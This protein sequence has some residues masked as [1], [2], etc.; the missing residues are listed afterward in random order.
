MYYLLRAEKVFV[1]TGG[2]INLFFCN[3]AEYYMLWHG[4]PLKKILNDDNYSKNSRKNSYNEFLEK[5]FVWKANF[6][7]QKKLYTISNSPF[8]NSY[9]ESAFNLPRE[10]IFQ[11]GSPRCDALFF[12]KIH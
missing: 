1:T 11:T 4:M 9:L 7:K 8:F 3:G 10:K 12:N 5:T 6:T 2:E